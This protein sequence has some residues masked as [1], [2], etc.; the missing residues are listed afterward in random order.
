[1]RGGLER[2]YEGRPF[3]PI[4]R[5]TSRD[6]SFDDIVYK[7]KSVKGSGSQIKVIASHPVTERQP[8]ILLLRL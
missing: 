5:W 4:R 6:D 7:L 2:Q 3:V 1:M 8:D